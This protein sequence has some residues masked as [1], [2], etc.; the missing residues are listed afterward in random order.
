MADGV[1]DE[2]LCS[3]GVRG[4]GT[5]TA[6]G[7]G[8]ELG[9][10]D[11]RRHRRMTWARQRT[12]S[13]AVVVV[14][15]ASFP[16]GTAAAAGAPVPSPPATTGAPPPAASQAAQAA[17]T[18]A[19]IKDVPLP[20]IPPVDRAI[21]AGQDPAV[22]LARA[23]ALITAGQKAAPL[24]TGLSGVEA[25]V[26]G[27]TVTA[28]QATAAATAA[29]ARAAKADQAA[30]QLRAGVKSL[31][32]ALRQ[33]T[34]SLYMSGRPSAVP[35]LQ[36]GN[37]DAVM[38][39][40]I[41]EQI[42][43]SPNGILAERKQAAANAERAAA[44]ARSDQRAA[45]AAAGYAAQTTAA[46]ADQ[47]T[48]MRNELATLDAA[49][50]RTLQTEA[51]SVSQQAGKDLAAASSLQFAPAA[52]IPPPVATTSVALTWLFSELGKTYV[53]GATGP[54]TF[55]CSG[56]TQFVWNK[57][58]VSVPRVAIDPDSYAI[59]VPL[60]DLRPGD[61]V[62]FGADVHHMGMYI[63]G[64]LMINAP[65]TGDVVRVSSIWFS[66]L[67]GFGR[68]HSPGTPVPSRAPILATVPNAVVPTLG[69]VPS[70]T[71]PP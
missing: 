37:G 19:A 23:I 18:A 31:D 28:S 6:S 33:A 62:F 66:D 48:A 56:L 5:T 9:G 42:A 34:L 20:A 17:A 35:D 1:G 15:M 53:Y 57:A 69:A 39:A 38:A 64:G 51:T 2:A 52:P 40:V 54:A 70:Q 59:P 29:D 30:G 60:S 16:A 61:L 24:Q 3:A 50:A 71:A 49:T 14:A 21:T 47:V 67:V 25:N 44:A 43:L 10:V 55:D 26:N 22:L 46:A 58:G 45:D 36:A 13:V 4:K 32:G 8:T 7:S 65:H 41:G 11:D 68:V 63:G 12:L 27:D